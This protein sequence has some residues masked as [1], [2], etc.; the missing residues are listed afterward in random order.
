MVTSTICLNAAKHPH[1]TSPLTG[2]AIFSELLVIVPANQDIYHLLLRPL[3]SLLSACLTKMDA[4]VVNAM[5]AL[6]CGHYTN[7][8]STAIIAF[9]TN[10]LR[11]ISLR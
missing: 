6:G 8:A 3:M 9:A 11:S 4:T 10:V 2:K 7:P 1:P 5:K